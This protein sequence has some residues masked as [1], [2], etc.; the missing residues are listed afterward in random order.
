MTLLEVLTLLNFLGL[1]ALITSLVV[2]TNDLRNDSEEG[3]RMLSSELQN[4]RE[5]R[6][7]LAERQGEL[8]NM[9]A[10]LERGSK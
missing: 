1:V 5:A 4:E 2:M 7:R 9:V 10:K 3:Y 6:W 8:A